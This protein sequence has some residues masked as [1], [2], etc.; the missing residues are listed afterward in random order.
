MKTPAW[1]RAQ[2]TTVLWVT[3]PLP[4]VPSYLGKREHTPRAHPGV[5]LTGPGGVK[6]GGQWFQLKFTVSL[7]TEE[8]NKLMQ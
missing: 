6:R 7:R 1:L 8:S 4:T 3:V 2:S 5:S